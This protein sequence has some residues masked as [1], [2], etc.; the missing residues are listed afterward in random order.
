MGGDRPSNLSKLIPLVP[1]RQLLLDC[2]T[3]EK[4]T[5]KLGWNPRDLLVCKIEE[6]AQRPNNESANRASPQNPSIAAP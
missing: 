5:E 4:S 2:A 6:V 3:E 1:A